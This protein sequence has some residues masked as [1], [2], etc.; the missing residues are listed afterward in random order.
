MRTILVPE[1]RYK[2]LGRGD[3][4]TRT[5][6]GQCPALPTR[7]KIPF[8][9]GQLSRRGFLAASVA[10]GFALAARDQSNTQVQSSATTVVINTSSGRKWR[11]RGTYYR[12]T[13][14]GPLGGERVEASARSA[15]PAM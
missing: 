14:L 3:E 7:R 8:D 15:A 12:D 4:S 13:P 5:R 9:A 11:V 1:A 6:S 2:I 10:G